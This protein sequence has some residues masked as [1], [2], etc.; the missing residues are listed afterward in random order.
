MPKYY[1]G[2]LR[3]MIYR[4]RKFKDVLD[5]ELR[6]EIEENAQNITDRIAI[7]LYVDGSNGK[8][9]N[10]EEIMS[11]QPYRPR[12]IRKKK[13]KGQPYDRVTLN[14]TGKFYNSLKVITDSNGFY[15]TSDDYKAQY[16]I[17]KYGYEILRLTELSLNII[18]RDHIRPSLEKKLKNYL[19]K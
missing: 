19:L 15:V 17:K 3:N 12:T 10:G 11:Y 8:G 1:N 14:D 6:N 7:Q 18:I 4:L 2:T 13:R 16:L 5:S 9:Y